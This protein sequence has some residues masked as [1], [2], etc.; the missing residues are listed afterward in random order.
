[1]LDVWGNVTVT[2]RSQASGCPCY[3]SRGGNYL[4]LTSCPSS[5]RQLRRAHKRCPRDTGKPVTGGAGGPAWEVTRGQTLGTSLTRASPSVS[6]APW[7]LLSLSA[8]VQPG[9]GDV[10]TTGTIEESTQLPWNALDNGVRSACP[11]TA[12]PVGRAPP[13]GATAL[14]LCLGT[15]EAES[16]V[17][18]AHHTSPSL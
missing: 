14:A 2:A 8:R 3:L 6:Q 4:T 7:G 12:R 15:A 5:P 18:G 1:M 11:N 17:L 9:L 10:H 16:S 13:A